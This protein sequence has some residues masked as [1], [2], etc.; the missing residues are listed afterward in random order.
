MTKKIIYSDAL[1][2]SN[3]M[4]FDGCGQSVEDLSIQTLQK[5]KAQ[6]LLPDHAELIF[7]AAPE[8]L[9]HQRVMLEL[10]AEEPTALLSEALQAQIRFQLKKTLADAGFDSTD[11]QQSS[12]QSSLKRSNWINILINVLAI[13]AMTGLSLL[14]PTSVPLTMSFTALTMLATAFTAR[15]YLLNFYRNLRQKKLATMATPIT[16]GWFLSLAH[17]SYH[18]V[19]MPMGGS[20]SM[21]LMNFIM[22]VTLMLLV[23]GMDEMKRMV[24]SQSQ[25]LQLRDIKSLFPQMASEYDCYAL[26]ASAL[27]EIKSLLEA[28]TQ[29]QEQLH[30]VT[31]IIQQRLACQEPVKCRQQALKSGMLIVVKRGECFPVDGCIVQGQTIIDASILTGE[32]RQATQ[33][34]DAIPAGAINLG[35]DVMILARLNGYHSSANRLLFRSNRAVVR[36]NPVT[37]SRKIFPYLFAALIVISLAAAVLT[38]FGL[39]ILTIPLLLQ[40]VTGILFA[41]CPCTMVLAHELPKLLSHYQ[42]HKQG[43]VLRDAQLTE[44]SDEI[45][46]VVFDKTGTLTTGSSQVESFEGISAP[47]WQKIYLLEKRHGAEH[48]LAKAISQ[49]YET[50]YPPTHEQSGSR[51]FAEDVSQAVRDERHRGLS[52]MVQ[53]VHIHIGNAE[54]LTSN[55]IALPA[56]CSAAIEA[57]LMLGYTPVYVAENGV[58][59]G[60]LLI[61]HEIRK[62][63]LA[64][65]ARLKAQKKRLIMLTGDTEASAIAFNQ[66][67]G[68]LF[69]PGEI[70][71]KQ[72]PR[73]KEQFLEQLMNAKTDTGACDPKGIWF[74]GDGLNDAPCARIVT[75]KGGVSCAMTANDKAAFFT[76]VSLNGR[77]DYL[78]QH[79][80]LNRFFKKNTR[81]N[82]GL[83]AYGGLAFLAFIITLSIVGVAVPPLIPMFIMSLTTIAVLFNS[84]RVKLSA[85]QQLSEPEERRPWISRALASDASIGLLLLATT[86]L[87]GGLL[88]ATIASGGLALP[89]MVFT[90]GI[91]VAMSSVLTIAA[92]AL[93]AVFTALVV[94]HC[95]AKRCSGNPDDKGAP[96]AERQG[97]S[98]VSS[99]EMGAT[100]SE[101]NP[102]LVHHA[103][104]VTTVRRDSRAEPG[105]VQNPHQRATLPNTQ[106]CGVY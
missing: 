9:G 29:N 99:P 13:V 1:I 28:A 89:A 25:K 91:M 93:F 41:I 48:P 49:Y 36:E 79:N 38:P 42:R 78:F 7:H 76:D 83:L 47:L 34:L 105:V 20:F 26:E 86:L 70:H 103:G 66:Q 43:I 30:A 51:M 21:T 92:T 23:N 106:V 85:E 82:Q 61:K 33:L 16:L 10:E 59:Q 14:L 44:C 57:K 2:V 90:A 75:E 46:T 95:I 22:P 40:N 17:T 101:P 52:A 8:E 58:Y 35:S 31:E 88:I 32:Y 94:G 12:Q 84:Y 69:A 6:G 100:E 60:V 73:D 68:H 62:D 24:R 72:S 27:V 87:I 65:L 77:L 53:G 39:G 18:S 96:A 56:Q 102:A 81:Q 3:T 63:I 80:Q 11:G 71:A 5:L 54:Y 4:C 64:G 55:N 50:S 37:K 15:N 19:M 97:L 74:V 67:L 98:P 104:I 45:H